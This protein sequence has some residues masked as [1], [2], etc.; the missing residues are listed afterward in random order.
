MYTSI[1]ALHLLG[2]LTTG[3][4]ALFGVGALLRATS[5]YYAPVARMLAVL[6]AV[7]IGTGAALAVL[8]PN[9][10]AAGMCQQLALYLVAVGAVEIGLF[11]GMRSSLVAFPLRTS[12]VPFAS[13]FAIFTVVAIAGF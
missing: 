5:H 2:A 11:V 3:V 4:V 9:L 10:S 7:E 8:S 6:A 13:S 1:L 12:V